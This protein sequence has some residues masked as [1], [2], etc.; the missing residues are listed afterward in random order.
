MIQFTPLSER[1]QVVQD[2]NVLQDQITQLQ[3]E[4]ASNQQYTEPDQAPSTVVASMTLSSELATAGW[5]TSN[6]T[7]ASEV[8]S[9]T[10]GALE[11]MVAL[12]N[13]ASSLAVQASNPTSD[14]PGGLEAMATTAEGYVQQFAALLN[15]QANGVSVFAGAN[16]YSAVT[17]GTS[18]VNV[19]APGSTA[20]AWQLPVESDVSVTVTANGYEPGIVPGSTSIFQNTLGAL[21][22][23]VSAINA[24]TPSVAEAALN[25]VAT[26]LNTLTTYMG[27]QQQNVATY[28]QQVATASTALQVDLTTNDGVNLPNVLSQMTADTTAYQAALQST[29]ALLQMSLWS[30]IT[31]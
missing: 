18:L 6:L 27:A 11:N 19:P 29:G 22:G 17:Q 9:T 3:G 23:L 31:L 4:A 14:V 20:W 13:Q 28:T 10:S 2:T 15:T 24:H 5:D 21:Q 30:H 16:P 7:T 8:L 12:V 1:T 26:Q 25:S